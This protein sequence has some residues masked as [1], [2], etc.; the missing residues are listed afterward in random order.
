MMSL[1]RNLAV[2]LLFLTPDPFLRFSSPLL[3][4]RAV[5]T[6]HPIT[7]PRILFVPGGG[8]EDYEEDLDRYSP[9]PIVPF[10]AKPPLRR[11]T[12]LCQYD[13]CLENQEPCSR[14]ANQTGCLCPG[15]SGP[16]Q[17]P[18]APRLRALVSDGDGR[19]KVEV[20][21]CAPSS[22]VSGYRVVVEGSGGEPLEFGEALRRGLVGS[23]EAGAKVCVEAV[24]KAGRSTP[25]DFSC[26]R[27]TPPDSSDHALRAGVIGGGV[28]FLLVLCVAAV[29]LWKCH[30]CGKANRDSTE[31][32]GNP[33]YATE[34]NL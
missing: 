5:P 21:W 15:F 27:Y 25:S 7:L 6:S 11:E 28:A 30:V 19:G 18:Q 1:C 12:Q 16:D 9:P 29:I 20:H 8:T 33:S 34:G 13:S 14:L 4:A 26:Q 10:S 22:V 2:L 24:N 23:L 17:P 31:G 3:F 32:L